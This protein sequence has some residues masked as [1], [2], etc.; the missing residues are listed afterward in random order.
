VTTS[1]TP[2]ALIFHTRTFTVPAGSPAPANVT[3]AVTY[4]KPDGTLATPG[5]TQSGAVTYDGIGSATAT[6]K[7][8]IAASNTTRGTWRW[9]W[10]CTGDIVAA[11]QGIFYVVPDP[12][13]DAT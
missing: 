2:G 6:F 12:V 1:F 4:E 5:P 8:T 13:L 9:R 3:M 11:D 10:T 7:Y